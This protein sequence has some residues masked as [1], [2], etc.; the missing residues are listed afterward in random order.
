[1]LSKGGFF[2]SD[3]LIQQISDL[4][5]EDP[6]FQSLSQRRDVY[7]PFEALGAAEWK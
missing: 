1:M 7:C 5:M 2:M 3:D 4:I 6:D